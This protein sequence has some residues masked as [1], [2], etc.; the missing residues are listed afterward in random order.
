MAEL[1]Q[2][3]RL[4]IQQ[5]NVL[6]ESS[7][8]LALRVR[9]AEE[10]TKAAISQVVESTYESVVN[11]LQKKLDTSQSLVEELQRPTAYGV[12]SFYMINTYLI[13]TSTVHGFGGIPRACWDYVDQS[14]L[15]G[16]QNPLIA[17]ARPLSL[18]TPTIAI[19]H[20]EA[21][22]L[23]KICKERNK[24]QE[25]LSRRINVVLSEANEIQN[26]S[27][28]PSPATLGHFYETLFI[29]DVVIPGHFR[30]PQCTQQAWTPQFCAP[31]SPIHP[32]ADWLCTKCNSA[33]KLKSVR[34]HNDKAHFHGGGLEHLYNNQIALMY[35]AL[36]DRNVDVTLDDSKRTRIYVVIVNRSFLNRPGAQTLHY[37]TLPIGELSFFRSA[38]TARV[39]TRTS[40]TISIHNA[41][42]GLV[43]GIDD[44][45]SR[46]RQG[47]TTLLPEF[48][49]PGGTPATFFSNSKA[50]TVGIKTIT[51]RLRTLVANLSIQEQ[52]AEDTNMPPSPMIPACI[53]EM[54][55]PPDQMHPVFLAHVNR[56]NLL[57]K[58]FL[59][60]EGLVT[61]SLPSACVPLSSTVNFE[62][63]KTND[64]TFPTL[65][66]L[67]FWEEYKPTNKNNMKDYF[68]TLGKISESLGFPDMADWVVYPAIGDGNCGV[69]ALQAMLYAMGKSTSPGFPPHSA[70][71]ADP[72]KT[73]V[74]FR[75]S[76]Q[77]LFL[78]ILHDQEFQE[79]WTRIFPG[80]PLF[81]LR[82]E[83]SNV[84]QAN[85]QYAQAPQ[86][87]TQVLPATNTFLECTRPLLGFALLAEC[88][89]IV[90][91][92][93]G[94][95]SVYDGRSPDFIKHYTPSREL[96]L[97]EFDMKTFHIV[98]SKTSGVEHYDFMI[99]QKFVHP[100]DRAF[101][102]SFQ[103]IPEQPRKSQRK[104]QRVA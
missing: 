55:T 2:T 27:Q 12:V 61:T 82:E 48:M 72:Y 29:N 88:Q 101:L 26:C 77:F 13:A 50:S 103:L 5:H 58:T 60:L 9:S 23:I 41:W 45:E 10:T 40:R 104:R 33:F 6:V 56:K 43:A 94:V 96:T 49:E 31:H 19:L 64:T 25:T 68:A 74:N 42:R 3:N 54:P 38:W 57:Q 35:N 99:H 15:M 24:I 20:E 37:W 80:I 69:Y 30:C 76:L 44:Y 52:S 85:A 98:H 81:V 51:S 14:Y 34:P 59:Y 32:W 100:D 71:Q 65:L 4:V 21:Q 102:R 84:Y 93:S 18:M 90:H 8:I 62:F 86:G 89:V 67:P 11:Q 91:T 73:A 66:S 53:R 75:K 78:A 79:N 47:L 28:D 16:M 46:I 1:Q 97:Q 63:P 70:W 83:I 7:R 22:Y 39:S 95:A 36:K 17:S 87:R 92:N